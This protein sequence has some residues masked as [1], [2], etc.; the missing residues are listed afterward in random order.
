MLSDVREDFLV[1]L[2]WAQGEAKENPGVPALCPLP[3]FLGASLQLSD[4]GGG[5]FRFLASNAD[6]TVKVRKADHASTMASAQVWL[7]SA[8]LHRLGYR[9]AMEEMAAWVKLWAPGGVIQP[10]AFHP[11]A[12]TQG[13]QPTFDDF[14]GGIEQR[15]FVCPVARPTLIPYEAGHIGYLRFG[16]GGKQGS[17]SGAAPIQ[18]AVYD[19]SEEIRQSDKGWFVP[20]WA[21]NSAYKDDEIVTRIEPRF[22]REYLAD[23]GIETQEQLLAAMGSLFREALEWCRYCVPDEKESNRSR[24]K[25]RDEWGV[26]AAL[27]WGEVPAAPLSRIDQARPKLERTLAAIGGHYVTL[28]AMLVDALDVDLRQLAEITVPAI[29]KRWEARK[30]DYAEKVQSRVLRLGGVALA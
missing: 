17:R 25:T 11:C 9:R 29:L 30:E 16:T 3:P 23:K 10:T 6:V 21:Q 13:W 24:W 18:L 20:L 28:Q 8:C 22:T 1:L 14:A 19:K 5:T 4:H 26:L 15:A 27:E 7:S 2:D 12:D